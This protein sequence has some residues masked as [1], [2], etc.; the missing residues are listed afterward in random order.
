MI[1]KELLLLNPLAEHAASIVMNDD[2]IRDAPHLG[3][4]LPRVLVTAGDVVPVREQKLSVAALR[5]ECR[6][7]GKQL[8]AELHLY[9]KRR[10]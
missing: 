7:G 9:K 10:N 8:V 2:P 1:V 3:H 6:A 4:W 5:N